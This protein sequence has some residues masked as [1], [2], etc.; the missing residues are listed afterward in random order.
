MPQCQVNGVAHVR[1][2]VVQ[3][4][5]EAYKKCAKCAQVAVGVYV[6]CLLWQFCHEEGCQQRLY[7]RSS[8]R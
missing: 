8:R 5:N 6:W 7:M 1:V 4:A 2:G 3:N